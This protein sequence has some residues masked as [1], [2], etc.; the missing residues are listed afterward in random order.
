MQ[1]QTK[2]TSFNDFIGLKTY[3]YLD[4]LKCHAMTLW[5]YVKSFVKC[6]FFN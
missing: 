6:M 1:I 5:L 2:E 3:M 4:S